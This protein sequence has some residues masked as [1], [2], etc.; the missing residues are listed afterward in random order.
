MSKV[1]PKCSLSLASLLSSSAKKLPQP[2]AARAMAFS[3]VDRARVA[4]VDLVSVLIESN[5]ADKL[6]G[7]IPSERPEESVEKLAE[8]IITARLSLDS[9]RKVL[10]LPHVERVQSKKRS[11]AHLT[12]ALLNVGLTASSGGPRQ[13]A[14]TGKD[15]L[16]AVIDSGFDLTH[17]MFL[18]P[19]GKPRVEALL[20]Q[21]ADGTQKEF[22]AAEVMAS[23]AAG[24][25]PAMDTHG[26]GTHVA[27]IAGG[28]SHLGFQGVAPEARFLLVKTNFIDTD[29]AARWA[30]DKAKN[31]PCVINMSLGH[32]FGAHDGS[33]VEERLHEALIAPGKL[34]VISAGNERNDAIHIGGGFFPSESQT[35]A[36]D[37]LRPA[38]PAEG[39]SA[40][41]TLWYDQRDDFDIQLISPAG[42][43]YDAPA[44]ASQAHFSST[45]PVV[46]L[47]RQTFTP[48]GLIQ[49]QLQIQYTLSDTTMARLRGWRLRL[50]CKTAVIGRIDGWF[51]NSGF[52]V[53]QPH[54]LVE[55]ARTIGLSATGRGCITVASHVS[56]NAWTSDLGDESD[57]RA[58]VGRSS[59]FS[60]VGPTRDG[61][62]KPDISAPGQFITSSLSEGSRL[63]RADQRALV[64][65]RLLTI[66]GTSMAAPVVT[67][68]V[69]LMLQK[70]PKL[71]LDDALR[72]LAT[73]AARDAHTGSSDWTPD[74]GVGKIDVKAALNQL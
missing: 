27:G 15:V 54:P 23:L 70:K 30:F 62:H 65:D 52:A 41:L 17:P 29:R 33:D 60:S 21:D 61:R 14:E 19:S 74:Y 4:K 40:T 47:L 34:I 36:F 13:V 58:V 18:D 26:H 56:K 3:G 48:S 44:V 69:A 43:V 20:V 22:T 12:E 16:I 7:A 67:G 49:S 63:E 38:D 72:A 50:T 55:T 46:T 39:P 45:A 9:V 35:V 57:I 25:N 5:D 53:F 73:A 37:L 1:D 42:T 8:G 66:E 68:V 2:A 6:I 24:S 51:S 32:H 59:D 10:K 64:G 71:K 28:T 31:R 11:Q